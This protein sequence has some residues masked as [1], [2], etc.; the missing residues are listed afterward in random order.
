MSTEVALPN[1]HHGTSS[2][3]SQTDKY[4][5]MRLDH[6]LFGMKVDAIRDV[7]LPQTITPVPLAS[8][9]VVGLIN[10]RGRIVTAISLRQ[11]LKLNSKTPAKHRH[12]VVEY[13]NDMYSLLVD[14]VADVVDIGIGDIATNPENLSQE[15]KEVCQGV[16][17][18]ERDLMVVVDLDRILGYSASTSE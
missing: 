5:I 6:Q 14:S 17:P 12:V 11:K 7:L 3:D 15:W 16:Y 2:V 13:G 4:V 9:E 8:P 10:L 18:M 1:T